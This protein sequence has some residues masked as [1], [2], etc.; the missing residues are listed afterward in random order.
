MTMKPCIECGELSE[1]TRCPEHTDQSRPS[2]AVGYDRRWRKL[3]LRARAIQPWCSDC[4]ATTDL[5]GDHLRWPARTLADVD[6]VCRSCNDRR[7]PV[8]SSRDGGGKAQDADAGKPLPRRSSAL[9]PGMLPSN[10]GG[11]C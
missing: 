1:Q 4:G 10:G 3:S 6:V 11:S 8:R 7:G 9:E 2:H 5:T